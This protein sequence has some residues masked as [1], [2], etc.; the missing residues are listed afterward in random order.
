MWVPQGGGLEELQ[1]RV[2]VAVWHPN[3]GIAAYGLPFSESGLHVL[4]HAG[5]ALCHMLAPPSRIQG[6][7]LAERLFDLEH[8]GFHVSIVLRHIKSKLGT[9]LL[10][11]NECGFLRRVLLSEN[12][13]ACGCFSA[14]SGGN[15]CCPRSNSC[16]PPWTSWAIR[17]TSSSSSSAAS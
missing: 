10:L 1:R 16:L 2:A 11:A 12:G 9:L 14:A 4:D 15:D 8:L 3:P 13:L 7:A 17:C 5:K 6:R